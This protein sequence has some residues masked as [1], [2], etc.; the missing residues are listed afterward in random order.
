MNFESYLLI[1]FSGAVMGC[2]R[3]HFSHEIVR[4]IGW[5]RSYGQRQKVVR[6]PFLCINSVV[7]ATKMITHAACCS[8]LGG[9][10]V[11]VEVVEVALV[12]LVGRSGSGGG[13]RGRE[14]GR[15]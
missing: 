4:D 11:V 15:V 3:L 10:V 6:V 8:L 13:W 9:V 7:I 5:K 1:G 14:R 2:V 12:V